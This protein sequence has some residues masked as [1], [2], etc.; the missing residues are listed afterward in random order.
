MPW[1]MGHLQAWLKHA[2]INTREL[3]CVLLKPK[4][5]C[6]EEA[7]ASHRKGHREETWS[8]PEKSRR[9][10]PSSQ[11]APTASSMGRSL[12]MIQPP[13]SIQMT[14]TLIDTMW[15][16]ETPNEHSQPIESW[17][18][19]NPCCFRPLCFGMICYLAID[20]WYT[21]DENFKVPR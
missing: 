2:F 16:E 15:R 6:Y 7:Q 20:G 5:L 11:P 21:G 14:L 3:Q 19:I 13:S 9:W 18:I 12:W 1:P 4:L 8:I 17:E 10:T